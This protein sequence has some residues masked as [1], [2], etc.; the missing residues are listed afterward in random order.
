MIRCD[1]W[2]QVLPMKNSAPHLGR[3]ISLPPETIPCCMQSRKN[4]GSHV[5]REFRRKMPAHFFHDG[6]GLVAACLDNQLHCFRREPAF[7]GCLQPVPAADHL[8]PVMTLFAMHRHCHAHL[9]PIDLPGGDKRMMLTDS[10]RALI[11]SMKQG[12]P[13]WDLLGLPHIEN[14]PAIR[15]KLQNIQ[16]MDKKSIL[17]R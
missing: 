2:L 16:K 13:N 10:E 11:I 5:L 4:C 1:Q 6:F 3:S 8:P 12:E 7:T 9:L 15:W 14:L 17:R